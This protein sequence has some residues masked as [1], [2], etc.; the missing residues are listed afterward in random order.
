MIFWMWCDMVCYMLR[1]YWNGGY[2]YPSRLVRFR[3]AYKKYSL[4]YFTLLNSLVKGIH[5]SLGQKV[6]IMLFDSA[7]HFVGCWLESLDFTL[8]E[9]FLVEFSGKK[10][11]TLQ[12]RIVFCISLSYWRGLTF[13]RQIFTM[14]QYLLAHKRKLLEKLSRVKRENEK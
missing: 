9:I 1:I 4:V 13:I 14:W 10:G 7:S 3:I 6:K 2:S 12:N 8:M 5:I 11:F